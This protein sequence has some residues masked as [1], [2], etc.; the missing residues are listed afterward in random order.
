MSAIAQDAEI[1]PKALWEG[2]LV[3]RPW[4]DIPADVLAMEPEVLDAD[5]LRVGDCLDDD[6]KEVLTVRVPSIL[7]ALL[8]LR[9]PN[10]HQQA[11]RAMCGPQ[12]L[13]AIVEIAEFMHFWA[14]QGCNL[15]I[16]TDYEP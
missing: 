16:E 13:L 15:E 8:L 10:I 1:Q 14:R 7:A 3:V 9:S 12:E 6:Q 4:Y 5:V 11:M 2:M